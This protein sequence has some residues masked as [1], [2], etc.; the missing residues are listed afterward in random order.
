MYQL[1]QE[2]IRLCNGAN[3]DKKWADGVIE[4][5]KKQ[6]NCSNK[7]ALKYFIDFIKTW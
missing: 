3:V 1:K 6:R 5:F 2:L 4:G 7:A